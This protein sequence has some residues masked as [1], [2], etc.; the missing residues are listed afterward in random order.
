MAVSEEIERLQQELDVAVTLNSALSNQLS[1]TLHAV[2]RNPITQR[3]ASNEF[4]VAMLEALSVEAA[5]LRGER[6]R[7][8]I[9]QTGLRVI[10]GGAA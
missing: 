6:V 8:R 2:S 7:R 10:N 3:K 5:Y 1:Q 9:Q 4:E